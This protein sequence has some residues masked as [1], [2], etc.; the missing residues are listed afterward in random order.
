[1]KYRIIENPSYSNIF[2]IGFD[3]MPDSDAVKLFF[4]GVRLP[5]YPEMIA[6]VLQNE[7][8]YGDV[9]GVLFFKDLDAEDFADGDDFEP[10][11]VKL[12]NHYFGEEIIEVSLFKQMLLDFG[13]QLFNRYA[14]EIAEKGLTEEFKKQLELLAEQIHNAS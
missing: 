12:F 4:S 7:G 14:A 6:G 9:F 1:M 13:T 5:R 8:Y 10:H 3:L 2:S 11:Q